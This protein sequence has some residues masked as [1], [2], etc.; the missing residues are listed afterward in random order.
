[1]AP[2]TWPLNLSLFL[3]GFLAGRR[4]LLIRFAQ[5]RFR[6]TA[7]LAAG[8]SAGTVFYFIL[9]QLVD[10]E[11]G[12]PL[13]QTLIGLSY[14]FHCWGLASAYV[15]GLLLMLGSAAGARLLAPL[16]A[17]G[18]LALSNYLLQPIVIVPLCLIF[19]WFDRF[20]PSTALL[21]AMGVF[22]LIQL[23][24]S[25]IWLRRYLYGPA[26]WLW[27]LLTYGRAPPLKQAGDYAPV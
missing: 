3:L 14:I 25:L 18:R 24:F 13:R 23:P 16:A 2:F 10:S 5:D 11:K 1:M 20:T 27:R 12:L 6:L 19:G 21:L 4:Q 15:A 8:A 9:Q 7:I 22:F 17:I 26:E